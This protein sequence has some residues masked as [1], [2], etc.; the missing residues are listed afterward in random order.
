MRSRTR[1][2]R[3]G[4]TPGS[5]SYFTYNVFEDFEY[6]IIFQSEGIIVLVVPEI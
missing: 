6:E 4:F 5:Q 3:F 1:K 2:L